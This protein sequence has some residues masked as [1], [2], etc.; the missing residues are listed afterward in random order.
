MGAGLGQDLAS[1]NLADINAAAWIALCMAAFLAAVTQAPI[2]SFVIVMEMIDGHAMVV[3]LIAAAFLASLVSRAISPPL[4][5][6]LAHGFITHN[7]PAPPP[8]N[9]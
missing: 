4:Y 8:A 3:S 9:P 2:T 5:H 6:T 7:K 1:L